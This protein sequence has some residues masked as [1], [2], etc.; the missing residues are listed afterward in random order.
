[1]RIGLAQIQPQLGCLEQNL[2]K[3][4]QL[5]QQAKEEK[6]D[7][8]VFPELSLTGSRLLDLTYQ[9]A[10]K[11]TSEEIQLLIEQADEIDLLFGFVEHSP[12][13]HLYNTAIYASN[14]RLVHLHRK[15]YLSA[16]GSGDEV[17]YFGKGRSIQ[18]FE[19]R[20]GRL[21]LLIGE[22][23]WH[24]SLPYLLVMDGAELIIVISNSPVH[25]VTEDDLT[26]RQKWK[27][28]LRSQAMVY[29]S[30]FLF[31]NRVG[32]EEG[33]SF[34]GGSFVVNPYGKV[35]AEAALFQEEVLTV[36]VELDQVRQARF[37][38]PIIRDEDIHFTLQQLQ[39]IVQKPIG[40]RGTK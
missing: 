40:G 19:T 4:V 15:V 26:M 17:R 18:S 5:I 27:T 12:E 31:V 3:H 30:N 7:L 34:Y 25:G 39:R 32:C 20:L 9:V 23:A 6:M 16:S 2:Q 21:G 1:M 24:L 29:G 22:E 33:L 35:D 8:L 11:Q 10:K 37:Q 14:Q 38:T 36:E 13:H 28:T